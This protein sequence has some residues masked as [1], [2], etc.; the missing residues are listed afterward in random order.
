[1]CLSES[2]FG[3]PPSRLNSPFAPFLLTT[4]PFLQ[5]LHQQLKYVRYCSKGP[6]SV[7][8][9]LLPFALHPLFLSV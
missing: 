7:L 6:S 9:P 5:L 4:L 1:M 8:R 3:S 2:R